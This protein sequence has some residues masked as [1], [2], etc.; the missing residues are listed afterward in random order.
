MKNNRSKDHNRKD[1]LNPILFWD[2]EDIDIERNAC[3]VIARVLDFGNEKD[4]KT[5]RAIYSDKKIIEVIKKR[6]G[7]MPQTAKF[8]AVYFKIP[9]KEITCLK[10]YYQ[11]T[12]L[13]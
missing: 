5:L 6:R 4:I 9:L 13:R 1:I 7:L 2:A 12:P 10:K 8:W 3:Y 11:R